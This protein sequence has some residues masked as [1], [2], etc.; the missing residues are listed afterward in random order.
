MRTIVDTNFRPRKGR[1]PQLSSLAYCEDGSA[2]SPHRRDGATVVAHCEDGV[3]ASD[4]QQLPVQRRLYQV[5]P[6]T[7]VRVGLVRLGAT[8]R[9]RCNGTR[10][11]GV[12]W[13]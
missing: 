8:H 4:A 6:E 11:R 12:E 1:A 7:V 10:G 13:V 5:A 2:K 3:A 9:N